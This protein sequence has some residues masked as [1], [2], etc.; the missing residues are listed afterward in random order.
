MKFIAIVTGASSGVGREYALQ[1]AHGKGGPLDEIWAIARTESALK[2]LADTTDGTTIRPIPLDLSRTESFDEL[3]RLLDEEQ[4]RVVWLVNC[5]G[6]GVFG[7]FSEIGSAN[8]RMC[9]LMCDGV[10]EMCSRCLPHMGPG[11]RIINLSSIAGLIPQVELATYSACKA[12]VLELSRMLDHELKAAGIRVIAVC[13]RFM[14]THFLDEPGD[15]GAAERMTMIGFDDV[16]RVVARSLGYSV[17]D[18]GTYVPSHAMRLLA[19]LSK[20]IP[21]RALFKAEDLLFGHARRT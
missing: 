16:E 13:P 20:H 18:I 8:A 15:R 7:S 9:A 5:A 10:V 14:R 21:R 12:F 1:L 4:P 17:L 19:F 11:S 2:E 3:E 6:F